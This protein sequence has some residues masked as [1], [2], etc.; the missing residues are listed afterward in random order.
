MIR[1][2]QLNLNDLGEAWRL[3][4]EETEKLS[5]AIL[6]DLRELQM[7]SHRD[8]A[9]IPYRGS[10]VFRELMDGR[11]LLELRAAY[12][13]LRRLNCQSGVIDALE[14]VRGVI[15]DCLPSQGIK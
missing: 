4:S 8:P 13:T 12:V 1:Q 2:R 11:R 9:G 6:A 10:D 3:P 15:D 7:P 14:I 5:A